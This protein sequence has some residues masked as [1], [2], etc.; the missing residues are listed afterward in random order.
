MNEPQE[1]VRWDAAQSDAPDELRRALAALAAADRPGS[2]ELQRLRERLQTV[3]EAPAPRRLRLVQSFGGPMKLM[4]IGLVFVAAL[5][6]L[7]R[8]ERDRLEAPEVRSDGTKGFGS[9]FEEFGPTLSLRAPVENHATEPM[10]MN[11]AVA[12]NVAASGQAAITRPD[13]T[14]A[15]TGQ[16]HA[17][18][19]DT[20][21]RSP[22]QRKKRTSVARESVHGEGAHRAGA[23]D[24]VALETSSADLSL[25]NVVDTAILAN[26]STT[27]VIDDRPLMQQTEGA[28]ALA[29][30]LAV[31]A[32][33]SHSERPSRA[34]VVPAVSSRLSATDGGRSVLVDEATLLQRAR[35][36]A[37]ANP[38][39]ALLLLEE[40]K[41]RFPAGMLSPEREVIAIDLLRSL[42]RSQEAECRARDF[43]RN[44]PASIYLSRVKP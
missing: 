11:E 42:S 4:A 35:S 34:V 30:G 33:D 7:R 9:A 36:A 23:R 40:H 1:P 29:H 17:A 24:E 14:G 37:S 32:S 21:M 41:R 19:R 22:D 5:L 10:M 26:E 15:G 20:G 31:H 43:R 13:S 44:Y 12:K 25:H 3:F 18:V 6:G 27:T 16:A 2:V 38:E 8:Y 39:A 28:S